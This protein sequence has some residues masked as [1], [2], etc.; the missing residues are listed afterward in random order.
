MN[1]EPIFLYFFRFFA[2]LMLVIFMGMLYWSSTLQETQLI[3][4]R[5]TIQEIQR[6]LEN[7]QTQGLKVSQQNQKTQELALADMSLP[8]LLEA[9]PFYETTLPEMLGPDFKPHGTFE[10]STYA[11]PQ[12]LNPFAGWVDVSA[13]NSLCSVS[14]A[15]SQFGKYETLSPDMAIRMEERGIGTDK[16]EFWIFL[17]D[18][19]YWQPLNPN[20]FQG[21][22]TLASHFMEHHQVTADDFKFYFDALRNPYIQELG[23]LSFRTIYSEIKEIE[24]ID[25]LTFVVRWKT[26][27]IDGTQQILYR[28]RSLTGSLQPLASFVYKYF[29]DG[30]KIVEDDSDKDTYLTSSIW[31]QNFMEHWARNI[32]VSCGRWTFEQMSDQAIRFKRNPD[33]YQPLD[34]LA[35][36]IT[37]SFKESPSN[38]WQDFK[39]NKLDFHTLLPDQKAELE[40]FLKS[41]QYLSQKEKNAAIKRLEYVG[42]SY[43]FIGWNQT[44]PFFKS[45]KVR[46]AL[47][48]S[49]DRDRI[50]KQNLNGFAVPINGTFFRFSTAYDDSIQPWP[51]DPQRARNLLAEE[52][53]YDSDG[54]GIIDK[55]IDGKRVPFSF[56]LTYYVKNPTTKA[57]C[58]FI[59]TALKEVGIDCRLLGVDIADLSAAIE[60]KNF[61]AYYLAWMLGT[62]PE[63]PRQIWSSA[64][65]KER[66]SSNT[67][68]FANAEIDKIINQLEFESDREKRIELYHRFDRI[69]HEEQPYTFL[70]TPKVILLYREYLRNVFIPADEQKLIPGATVT[71]P[72][73]QVFYLDKQEG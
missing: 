43:T 59:A 30:T 32:I 71:E 24:V 57:I 46:Q 62:P 36:G 5:Q 10:R 48:M 44:K 51:F 49:I 14:V 29:P 31:G 23:A 22:V 47:T 61:D 9:D 15:Q 1:R 28:A 25:K 73:E 6:R 20:M 54:D 35:E 13:W 42:R 65:A 3:Q 21:D 56:Q 45:A 41:P 38:V 52:G 69:I 64:E 63:D 50:I 66:G 33:F 26:H 4:M 67:I 39:S 34:A 16:H 40:D 27:D 37:T 58:D 12:N 19:V 60:E 8:N 68:G 2:G 7:I 55:E 72:Q 11:R 70:Y 53:W 18:N 17:R